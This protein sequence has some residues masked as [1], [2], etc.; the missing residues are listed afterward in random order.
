MLICVVDTGSWN[1]DVD[2]FNWTMAA[3]AGRIDVPLFWGTLQASPIP[4][5][6]AVEEEHKE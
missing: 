3:G 1:G 2:P 5:C 6:L 4:I